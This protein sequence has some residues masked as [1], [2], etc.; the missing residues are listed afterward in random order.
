MGAEKSTRKTAG[1]SRHR[2]CAVLARGYVPGPGDYSEADMTLSPLA[3]QVYDVLRQRV[4]AERAPQTTYTKL[5]KS[6]GPK[7]VPN[8]AALAEALSE[9]AKACVEAELPPITAIAVQAASGIPGQPY[10]DLLHPGV[11]D[12]DR[13][14]RFRL[15]LVKVTRAKASYPEKLGAVAEEAAAEVEEEDAEK[16]A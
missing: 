3:A 7:V 11:A 13:P 12:G 5:A 2:R 8:N 9:I 1:E 14:M 6:M 4:L 10:F 16:S 15:D